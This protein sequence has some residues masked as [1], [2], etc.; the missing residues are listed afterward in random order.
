MI[1][2]ELPSINSNT[3]VTF[4]QDQPSILIVDNFYKEP[5]KIR[6]HALQQPY[7]E[8]LKFYKGLRSHDTLLLPY[9][10]EEFERLLGVQIVDWLQ[11]SANGIFQKT[12]KADP[13]VFHTDNQDFAGAVYLTPDLPPSMGTSMWRHKMSGCRRQPGH[14]LETESPTEEIFTKESLVSPSYWELV[15][16]IG[17]V[18]NRL[19]L[20]DAKLIHSASEYSTQTERLVQLFFFNIAH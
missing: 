4:T 19:V 17:A 9:V 18:Y 8:D 3:E 7:R 16:K 20:W 11:Q 10:K 14:P 15:D 5:D 6:E 13:L 1:Q 12:S 2:Y